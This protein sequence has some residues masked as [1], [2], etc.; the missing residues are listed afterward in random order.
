MGKEITMAEI[1]LEANTA[2]VREER[3]VAPAQPQT[4][5]REQ[6]FTRD[7]S[8]ELTGNNRVFV[9]GR[10][11]DGVRVVVNGQAVP[12]GRGYTLD[13]NAAGTT[14]LS[15]DNPPP[16][17]TTIQLVYN[18]RGT[19]QQVRRQDAQ[20]PIP[21]EPTKAEDIPGPPEPA[22]VAEPQPGQYTVGV[23]DEV[24]TEVT[25]TGVGAQPVPGG[26]VEGPDPQSQTGLPQAAGRTRTTADL[27][28]TP[29]TPGQSG[30]NVA[31]QSGTAGP[32]V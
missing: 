1:N 18:E 3:D 23:P 31:G 7:L 27:T 14:I 15:F 16:V 10:V 30:P 12:L 22:E 9:V 26:P 28:V 6:P 5:R 13:Q 4:A 21:V 11:T 19:A 2:Q 20:A 25:N 29:A 17:G 8:G 32:S 24:T